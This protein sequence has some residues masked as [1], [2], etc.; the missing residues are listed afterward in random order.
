[1]PEYLAPGVYVEEINITPKSIEGVSTTP[2]NKSEQ[3]AQQK[4]IKITKQ[5]I[6]PCTANKHAII[7]RVPFL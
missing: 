2:I 3:R 4:L 6:P 1:M 5:L 7:R